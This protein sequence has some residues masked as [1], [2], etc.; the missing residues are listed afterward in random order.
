MEEIDLKELLDMFLEKKFLI[1][2]VVIIATILGVIYTT[3]ILVPEYQ[4]S[5]SLVLVQVGGENLEDT[6]SITTTD[7]TLNSNLVD[8]YREIAKSKS[9]ATKVISN[10]N[11]DMS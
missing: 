4:S 1:I 8:D 6:N 11:L 2:I 9:V 3:K 10:L 5:T 7:I